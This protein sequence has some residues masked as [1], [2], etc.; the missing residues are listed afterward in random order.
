M[1]ED[2]LIEAVRALPCLREVNSKSYRDQRARENAWK[3]VAQTV[4]EFLEVYTPY[5]EKLLGSCSVYH[6]E[7]VKVEECGMH[8]EVEVNERPLCL[9]TA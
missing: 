6:G 8:E 1:D 9:R 4:R 5:P 2:K 3:E 7:G